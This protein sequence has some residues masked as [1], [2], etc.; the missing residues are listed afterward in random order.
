MTSPSQKLHD[1]NLPSVTRSPQ[2]VTGN[3]RHLA[4]AFLA[5][6]FLSGCH[7][8]PPAANFVPIDFEAPLD[9]LYDTSGDLIDEA[10]YVHRI[11]SAK[12]GYRWSRTFRTDSTAGSAV[13]HLVI[14]EL[15]IP[16]FRSITHQTL[17]MAELADA[18]GIVQKLAY[19]LDTNGRRRRVSAVVN[20]N[21]LHMQRTT[22]ISSKGGNQNTDGR[23]ETTQLP[24]SD[25][26]GGFQGIEQ[27]LR[28]KPLEP[29]QS[30]TVSMLQPRWATVFSRTT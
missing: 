11:G 12:V 1:R 28:R 23:V 15:E 18:H 20:G 2:P 26:I 14:D 7:D 19:E 27:S 13:R 22:G 8:A 24:W 3:L 4:A 30:R 17:R 9:M 10:W 6:Q 25:A 21:E 5:L 29:G 16:R